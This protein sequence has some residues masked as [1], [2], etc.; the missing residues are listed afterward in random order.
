MSMGVYQLLMRT[1]GAVIGASVARMMAATAGVSVAPAGPMV[2]A[3]PRRWK[4]PSWGNVVA[5]ALPAEDS[6][7]IPPAWTV[8][9]TPSIEFVA[10]ASVASSAAA[11]SFAPS[12]VV[13]VGLDCGR[14]CK[15]KT[16]GSGDESY[17]GP[18]AGQGYPIGKG[19]W[20]GMAQ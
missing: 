19:G 6:I 9:P 7:T 5:L 17:R 11:V 4:I 14:F 20:D 1:A 15:L 12:F 2:T 8:T 3:T 10:T 16:A 13:I 18:P